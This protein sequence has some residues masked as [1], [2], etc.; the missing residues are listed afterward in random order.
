MGVGPY[1]VFKPGHRAFFLKKTNMITSHYSTRTQ[2]LPESFIREILKVATQPGMI[3]FAGGLPNPS[4]F[5]DEKLSIA[6]ERVLQRDGKA[7]LQ[8]A[9]TEGYL[10]LR[11]YIA[12][13]HYAKEGRKTNAEDVLILNGSQQ[14]LDLAGKVFVDKGDRIA[15][16]DPAYLGAIQA[17][18]AYEPEFATVE[19]ADDGP[20]LD[21]LQ[22][23]LKSG[24]KFFYCIPNFQ[25]PTGTC[26]SDTIRSRVT[27]LLSENNIVCL[28]DD[29]Y[30]EIYF[31]ER[32]PMS[33]YKRY[34][35]TLYLGSFFK[36]ICPG[37]RLG[38]VTGSREDIR[39]FTVA[40][41]A[42]DLH[43]NNFA[44]RVLFQ[45]LLDNSLEGH[46]KQIRKFYREQA[47]LMME[48]I[49]KNFPESVRYTNPQGGM[50]M[51]V[52]LPGHMDANVVLKSAVAKNVLFVPGNSFFLDTK[53]GANKMRLNFSN[54]STEQMANGITILGNVLKEYL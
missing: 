42:S 54:A 48:L 26:Y 11:D 21:A 28:E 44:Q 40:K 53:G 50:F 23:V 49:K 17:F 32:P 27:E 36:I 6:A 33:I 41:Q 10:P 51:W 34:D 13:A 35:R 16:E 1:N 22:H 19:L 8:Y 12:S 20:R 30:G 52:T 18:S 46:L 45:F 3:S 7:V 15:M 29:P 43:S 38:W 14:G 2:N 31:D 5:P 24:P 39:R 4:F 9:P 25:N 47:H 37:L